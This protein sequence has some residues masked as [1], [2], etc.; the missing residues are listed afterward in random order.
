[1]AI[2]E[3]YLPL[4]LLLYILTLT[5]SYNTDYLIT[6]QQP[7]FNLIDLKQTLT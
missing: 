3:L 4:Q 6:T 5:A 2:K 7:T 1:M